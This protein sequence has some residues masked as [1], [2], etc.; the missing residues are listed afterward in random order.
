MPTNHPAEKPLAIASVKKPPTPQPSDEQIA[1]DRPIKTTRADINDLVMRAFDLINVGYRYGGKD[2]Q[3]G[4]DCSGFIHFL[5]KE[6]LAVDLPRST[7]EIRWEGQAIDPSLLRVGDLVFFNTL[8]RAFS[9]VG[10]YIGENRF[11]HAPS[12][13]KKV[14]ID[15]MKS[16]YWVRRFNGARRVVDV[17]NPKVSPQ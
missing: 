12:Q 7:K 1:P 6:Q 10:I 13:G 2:P 11:I 14:R 4:F 17:F 15:D 16:A 8:G 5:F 3:S 9:H